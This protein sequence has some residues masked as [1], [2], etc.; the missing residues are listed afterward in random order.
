MNHGKFWC[1][2]DC[3]DAF[4]LSQPMIGV[5]MNIDAAG[6]LHAHVNHP[7]SDHR[8]ALIAAERVAGV[9][10]VACYLAWYE[11]TYRTPFTMSG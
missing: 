7:E 2:F 10:H 3:A 5:E 4:D 1:I 11:Q 8:G 9:A 6:K